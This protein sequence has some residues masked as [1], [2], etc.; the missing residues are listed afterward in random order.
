MEDT[1]FIL[2]IDGGG[3]RGLIPAIILS[4][5]EKRVTDEIK[6]RVT[7]EIKKEH[8]DVDIRCADLFDI[9][10]GTSTGSI[11]ALSLSIAEKN[12]RPK[13]N[14][15]S[16]VNFYKEHGYDVFPAYSNFNKV[17]SKTDKSSTTSTEKEFIKVEEN[18]KNITDV[19]EKKTDVIT[20]KKTDV[21]IKNK[22][23]AT[24]KNE[25]DATIKNKV[26]A[27]ITEN[28]TDIT[29]ST[30]SKNTTIMAYLEA[31]AVANNPW[32]PKYLPKPFE[33]LLEQSFK[34]TKLKDTIN[35]MIVII[36]SYDITNSEYILFTNNNIEHKELFMKDV[37]RASAAAPTF[38]PAKQIGTNYFIDGGVFSN[39]PTVVAYLEA[40]KM[41][42]NSKFVV[43]SLGTGYY[44]EPLECYKNCGIVQWL[45]PLINLLF[46]S[47]VDNHDT[48]MKHFA[49]FDGTRYF[50]IQLQLTKDDNTIDDASEKEAIK[51]TKLAYEAIDDPKN[52]F[53][54]IIDLLVDK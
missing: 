7:D 19:T 16:I 28:K 46:N 52:N 35:D 8:Q 13:F 29:I 18:I 24:I 27:T 41:Y 14:A 38:F 17:W 25:T 50:R 37:I 40:K 34:Q 54:E 12:N 32:M 30:A 31:F 44:K 26:D 39:N 51:L 20:E 3:F 48:I 5:I 4:E 23:D 22:T 9:M 2:S 49:K 11:I 15:E 42:P 33:D 6:K 1:K 45:K 10:A 53:K 36:P 21:I 43:V 47:E